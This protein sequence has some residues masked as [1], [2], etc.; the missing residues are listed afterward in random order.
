MDKYEFT[1]HEDNEVLFFVDEEGYLEI[2]WE[3]DFIEEYKKTHELGK[4]YWVLSVP[5]SWE[6]DIYK[7][8]TTIFIRAYKG[9]ST[10]E[11]SVLDFQRLYG[12]YYVKIL[13]DTLDKMLRAWT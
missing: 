2:A 6:L 12:N 9:S 3:R 1:D 13:L 7:Y 5:N 10:I 11:L 8:K 4:D